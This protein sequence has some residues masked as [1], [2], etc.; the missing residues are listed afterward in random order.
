MTDPLVLTGR[1]V[2]FDSA[3]PV[4]EAGA[5]YIGS[6]EKIAA[7]QP[8]SAPPPAGFEEVK[9][10]KTGGTIYPG[11]ID[12]HGHMVY[13]CLSLWS[14]AERHTPYTTRYQWPDADDYK[15]RIGNPANALGALAGKAMLRYV[16][17]KAVI[18]GTTAVQGSTKMA[19]PYEGWLVRNV[20]RE[21]FKTGEQLVYQS[22]LQL[23]SEKKYED[24]AKHMKE[25]KAF[26]YHL[27]EG[28]DPNLIKEYLKL[29]DHGCLQPTLG[30]IH[31]T[32]LAEPNYEEWAPHGGSV[33]WSPFSNLWLYAGTTKVELAKQAGVRICL[34]A[35]WSPSGSKNL[36]GELK[37]ADMWNRK[38]LGKAF[39][40]EEICAMATANPA[41]ALGWGDRLGRLKAGLHG[42]VLVIKD[43]LTDPY[44]NLIRAVEKDVLF[45]A[46]NGQPFYG[47]TELM[48]KAGASKAEP[49]QVGGLHRRIVLVYDGVPDADMGW[50]EALDD[51]EAAKRD[52]VARY[53]KIEEAHKKK[54]KQPPWLMA[55]K[56]WDDPL[57]TGKE[58]SVAVEIP[59][60]DSLTHDAAYFR[61]I[62]AG[63]ELHQGKL[64][65][66]R[67]YYS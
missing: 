58:V 36:L 65:A 13:N 9:P 56:P 25:G 49:I 47:T 29:R 3:N 57:H 4:I 59:P 35:D 64:D 28:T 20:E 16:E 48:E 54:K 43:R 30:A 41:D 17:V 6:D 14:P 38:E 61:A 66:L 22:A 40:D 23:T 60:L 21:T 18:G 63:K 55:D 7:V 5:L 2:T 24:S 27:S 52:P 19:K 15:E 26:L 42:D 1:L 32:A 12:L 8:A 33:I 34:G 45:V 67:D 31:C 10:V 44:R 62:E 46:I 37:V 53:L 39:S 11:L 50:Q 51:I